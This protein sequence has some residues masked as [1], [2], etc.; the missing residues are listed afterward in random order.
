MQKIT[1]TIENP[2]ESQSVEL[3][4]ELSIG[5][6]PDAD[7]TIDDVGLSRVNTTVFRDGEMIFAVDE[8]STNGTFVNGEKIGNQPRRIFDGDVLKIGSETRIRVESGELRV[9]S[10]IEPEITNQ[11]QTEETAKDKGQRTKDKTDKTK[12]QKPKTKGL[13]FPLILAAGLTFVFIVAAIIAIVL[14]KKF[15]DTAGNTN[16]KKTPKISTNAVIPIR[17]IDPLGGQTPEDLQDLTQLWEVQE[18]EVEATDLEDVTASA[19]TDSKSPDAS[20]Q[21]ESQR[22]LLAATAGKST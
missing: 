19:P 6:T 18:K 20:R 16:T 21:S 9:A 1:L 8:N 3:E 2:R 13:P 5:R 14:V 15:E 22:R 12:N 7:I 17:V 4:N 11:T 10:E